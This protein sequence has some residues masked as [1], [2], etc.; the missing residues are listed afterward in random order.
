MLLCLALN[1]GALLPAQPPEAAAAGGP[2]AELAQFRLETLAARLTTMP[3]GP[4]R[5]YFAGVLANRTGRIEDSIRLLMSALPG[6]RKAQPARAAVAL[7]ALADDYNK[8]FRYADAAETYDDLLEHFSAQL[9][10][11]H[12]QGTRDDAGVAHLL[13][14]ASPQTITWQGPVRMKT[15]RDP[16]GSLVTELVVNGVR[17]RWLLDTGANL[18]VVSR[19]FARRLGLEPLPGFAETQSGITGVKNPV[20]VAVLPELR[21]EG[22]TLHNVVVMI[23]NDANLKVGPGKRAYQIDAIVGYPV[24]QALGVI[25]FLHD[26]WF[27]AGDAARNAA[28]ATHMY[29]KTLTPVIVCGV[30]GEDL[31][32]SLDTGASGSNLSQLYYDR[33]RDRAASWKWKKGENRSAGAGGVVRR[34]IYLQP[35]LNLAV[36]DRTVTLE[37]VPIFTEQIGTDIDELYGNLGQDLVAGFASFTLDFSKM[38][39]SLGPPLAP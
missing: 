33:F 23:L 30:G 28:A 22:A 19:S 1:L 26:G 39:F 8:S 37:R 34:T 38:T 9:T 5:D 7:E 27:V 15:V 17:E 13:H 4:E 2:D 16:I 12:L 36:G 29:M 18:S 21:M 3:A 14:G 35:E 32:F 11:G 31:P 20:Q 6:I 10:A 25:S 24:F